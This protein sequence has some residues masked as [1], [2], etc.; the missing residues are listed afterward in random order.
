MLNE[1]GVLFLVPMLRVKAIDLGN[2]AGAWE[3]ENCPNYCEI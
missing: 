3:R 2:C 1:T